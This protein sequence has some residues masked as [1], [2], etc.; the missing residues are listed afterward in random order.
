MLSIKEMKTRIGILIKGNLVCNKDLIIGGGYDIHLCKEDEVDGRFDI[1]D[2]TVIEGD[3]VVD[4]FVCRADVLVTGAC[5][6]KGG[7]H[8]QL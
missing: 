1:S 8:V 3:V 5:S 2:A 4:D 6:A 7:V